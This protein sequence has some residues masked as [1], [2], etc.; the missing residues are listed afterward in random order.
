MIYTSKPFAFPHYGLVAGRIE[1]DLAHEQ[2]PLQRHIWTR[3]DGT[4]DAEKW[5]P[6]IR[7]TPESLLAKGWKLV[8]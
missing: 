4:I 8:A 6:T 2:R 5:I 1:I 3:A 7:A